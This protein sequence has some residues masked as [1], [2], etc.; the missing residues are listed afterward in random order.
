M[1]IME[2][3]VTEKEW[4]LI[5]GLFLA[6]VLRSL[7]VGAG[8]ASVSEKLFLSIS[9][10]SGVKSLLIDLLILYL[11]VLICKIMH[12]LF[13][14]ILQKSIT[15]RLQ[16]KMVNKL[17]NA[18]DLNI[19]EKGEVFT[20]IDKRAQS[21]ATDSVNYLVKFFTVTFG[22]IFSGI[23]I[24]NKNKQLLLYILLAGIL[25]IFFMTRKGNAQVAKLNQ[26]FMEKDNQIS[27]Y[28]WEYIRN[29][30]SAAYLNSHKIFEKLHER[31][32]EAYHLSVN[33]QKLFAIAYLAG[34]F[35]SVIVIIL[36]CFAGGILINQGT[37]TIASLF[38]IVTLL[39]N[40]CQ[41]LF[42]TPSLIADFKKLKGLN[43]TLNTFFEQIEEDDSL[44]KSEE[45]SQPI[46]K[47][48]CEGIQFSY[49]D[50]KIL[51]NINIQFEK[52]KMYAI[53]GE[54][55]SGKS[56]LL[57]IIAK[58]LSPNS[59]VVKFNDT[60]SIKLNRTALWKKV[61]YMNQTSM[62]LPASI[63]KNITCN[64]KL[65]K[66]KAEKCLETVS[67]TS[68]LDYNAVVEEGSL[69]A[70]EKQKI[71][72]ARILYNDYDVILLDEPTS[73]L[74]P[75]SQTFIAEKLSQQKADKIII[76][77]THTQQVAKFADEVYE[78]NQS[79]ISR[80]IYD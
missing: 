10:G 74:D 39:P 35:G 48:A 76:L 64:Q 17:K 15:L 11:L 72:L 45:I 1:K 27:A 14:P 63:Y 59:G 22:V 28:Q 41:S 49:G 12:N 13:V 66:Q 52:G 9:A 33:M 29:R 54:S 78:I 71:A 7:W 24:Y 32:Q 26:Q 69:S 68:K 58:S 80:C 56:T 4:L 61:A 67:F 23:F 20:Q 8:V 38:A 3:K 53:I 21:L 31:N 57:K 25:C 79:K 50:K 62:I 36:S 6:T 16:N 55:G 37:L 65:D 75:H 47:I 34:Q 30:E 2:K 19:N 42:S 40:F 18:A 5:V 73:A 51:E 60:P 44:H 77:V 70:G 46:E 43:A